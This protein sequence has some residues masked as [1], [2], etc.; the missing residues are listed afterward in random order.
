MAEIFIK[1]GRFEI[2]YEILSLCRVSVQKTRILYR[3]NLSYEQ[4][5]KYIEYLIGK[6]LLMTFKNE[7]K[8][9]YQITENGKAFIEGYEQIQGLLYPQI[10]KSNYRNR[11]K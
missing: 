11:R 6:D 9:F 10:R 3:C 2:V 5:L 7:G 4:L 8:D 1:R